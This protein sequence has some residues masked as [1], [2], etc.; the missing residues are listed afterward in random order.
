LI[1]VFFYG[2]SYG[3]AFGYYIKNQVQ[4]RIQLDYQNQKKLEYFT[5]DDYYHEFTPFDRMHLSLSDQQ[6]YKDVSNLERGN[7][8]LGNFVFEGMQV[9]IIITRL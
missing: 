9:I 2:G 4:F 7:H 6:S 5:I 1:G 8:F 3:N